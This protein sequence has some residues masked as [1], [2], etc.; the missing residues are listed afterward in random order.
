MDTATLPVRFSLLR[1][2]LLD[3]ADFPLLQVHHG[4]SPLLDARLWSRAL[5]V[6]QERDAVL[7]SMVRL[8]SFPPS[9][10]LS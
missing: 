1:L 8:T 4:D 10:P 2:L 3:V 7:H 9:G 6:A 5:H